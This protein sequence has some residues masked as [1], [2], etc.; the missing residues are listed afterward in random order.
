MANKLIAQKIDFK[1]VNTDYLVLPCVPFYINFH[2]VL[3]PGIGYGMVLVSGMAC[4][5]YNAVLSWVIYYLVHSFSGELP[6]ASCGHW[7]NSE[8]CIAHSGIRR[9]KHN[10]SYSENGTA[11]SLVHFGQNYSASEDNSSYSNITVFT[12]SALHSSF[13]NGSLVCGG[14]SSLCSKDVKFRTAAEE[15]WK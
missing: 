2:F 15:F 1:C 10:D 5:Y 3:L 11:V 13:N 8:N 14:N 12:S 4:I 7:W 6:W 9:Q